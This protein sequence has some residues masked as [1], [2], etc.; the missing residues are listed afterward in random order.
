MPRRSPIKHEVKT[1]KR[2]GKNVNRFPR[3][4]GSRSR[5]VQ[6]T[7]SSSAILKAKQKDFTIDEHRRK[8]KKIGDKISYLDK[9]K[10][11]SGDVVGIRAEYYLVERN[12][13]VWKVDR[14][15]IFTRI[16]SALKGVH[17]AALIAGREGVKA[18]KEKLS[19]LRPKIKD[20][21]REGRIALSDKLEERKE[22]LDNEKQAREAERINWRDWKTDMEKEEKENLQRDKAKAKRKQETKQ[23]RIRLRDGPLWK[24]ALKVAAREAK[25]ELLKKEPKPRKTPKSK[26]KPKKK[27][28]PKKKSSKQKKKDKQLV[29][30][31]AKLRRGIK[32]IKSPKK[33]EEIEIFLDEKDKDILQ[34]SKAEKQQLTRIVFP[35]ERK[36]GPQMRELTQEEREELK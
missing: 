7:G 30:D 10:R 15:S 6:T 28:K 36:R 31:V 29:K 26:V 22:R 5:T 3:G 9:G 34:F 2:R 21:V 12:G 4:S 18:T 23:Y 11:V 13:K 8:L 35:E 27:P 17:A 14:H 1:H 19:E 16:G 32:N 20:A 25:K 33:L 24:R